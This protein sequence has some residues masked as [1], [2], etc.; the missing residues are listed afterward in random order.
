MLHLFPN[1]I[2]SAKYN[3]VVAD[4]NKELKYFHNIIL[5]WNNFWKLGERQFYRLLNFEVVYFRDILNFE[6]LSILCNMSSRQHTLQV[7]ES[8]QSCLQFSTTSSQF[9]TS[10]KFRK[11]KP[12]TNSFLARSSIKKRE[13]NSNPLFDQEYLD[14]VVDKL[15]QGI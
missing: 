1:Q 3:F 5:L 8:V 11:L 10:G 9:M 7:I 6:M 4:K 13:K 2:S 12:V 15:L 14:K